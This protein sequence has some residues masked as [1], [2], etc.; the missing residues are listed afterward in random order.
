MS[1]SFKNFFN[2]ISND[3]RI[4]TREDISN[5]STKEFIKQE[6]AIDYQMMNLGIPTNNELKNRD[7]VVYVHEYLR[8]DGVHVKAHYRSKPDGIDANNLSRNNFTENHNATPVE[9]TLKYLSRGAKPVL[10]LADTNL[11]NSMRDFIRAKNDKNAHIISRQ[12]IHNKELNNLMDKVEIPKT[13]RGVIYDSNSEYGKKLWRSN[14]IQ[15]F[16]R[17]N[18]DNLFTGKINDVDINF[19]KKNDPDNFLGLQNCKLYKPHITK[20]G[21]FNGFI[22]DYYDFDHRDVKGLDDYINNWGY[23]MQEKGY[24]EKHFVIYHIHEKIF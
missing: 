4:F 14:E 3:N 18:L 23:S 24:L 8:G 10:P 1:F 19:L 12:E 15:T 2:K 22:I 17:N 6:K 9:T 13:S 5:M 16:V 21:Y 20:D 11:Q 7:D